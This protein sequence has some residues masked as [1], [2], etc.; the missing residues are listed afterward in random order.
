MGDPRAQMLEAEV[1]DL[2]RPIDVLNGA[3]VE[4]RSYTHTSGPVAGL[5]V[6]V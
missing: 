5:P 3:I 4:F 6:R 1:Q 2:R